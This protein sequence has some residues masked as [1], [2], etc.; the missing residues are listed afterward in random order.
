MYQQAAIG[1]KRCFWPNGHASVQCSR[2]MMVFEVCCTSGQCIKTRIISFSLL[3]MKFWSPSM[4]AQGCLL[5]EQVQHVIQIHV[6]PSSQSYGMAI[7]ERTCT[8]H[9]V[10]WPL[11]WLQSCTNCSERR[12]LSLWESSCLGSPVLLSDSFHPLESPPSFYE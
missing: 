12:Q 1:V 5:D 7:H 11:M 2:E 10:H 3:V 6:E 4:V 8:E 9:P